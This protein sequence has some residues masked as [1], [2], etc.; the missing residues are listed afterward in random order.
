MQGHC[1][2]PSS[3]LLDL[4]RRSLYVGY[5]CHLKDEVGEACLKD[6]K[7]SEPFFPCKL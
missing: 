7:P 6:G 5:V 4:S 1:G 2:T 3:L